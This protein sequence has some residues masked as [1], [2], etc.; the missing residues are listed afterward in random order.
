MKHLNLTT[1]ILTYNEEIHIR[2]ALENVCPISQKVIVVDSPSTD[3]TVE[4]CNEFSNV[5]VVVHK[6]PGNQADQFNWALDNCDIQTEWILRLDADEYC[7]PEL[8]AEMQEKLP[9]MPA[10]VSAIVTPIGREFM[11]RRLKHG[12]VNGV[13]LTRLLRPGKVRY[14]ASLMDEH[15]KVLEGDTEKFKYAIMDASRIPISSFID[16][17]NN[18]SSREAA[19]L[20]DAEFS[21]NDNDNDN[22]ALAKEVMAKRVQKAKYAKMPLFWRVFGYF[23]YRYIVKLGFLDGKEGFCWDFFQG[24]WYRM[25]VDAKV[26]Q[27]KKVCGNDKEALKAYILNKWKIRL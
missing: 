4:I 9:K 21:L 23:C 2:R 5:V 3:R 20:L 18:Y 27:A 17:H 11:G 8:I 13:S 10:N 26:Y 1:I 24:L 16:K 19:M 22:S 15:M 25:L 14:E 12:I 6:Y 7:E